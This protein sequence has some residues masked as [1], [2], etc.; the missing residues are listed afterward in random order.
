MAGLADEIAA[1]L[2]GLAGQSWIAVYDA[3]AESIL[4]KKGSG[5]EADPDLRDEENI[6]LLAGYLELDDRVQL[7]AVRE[8]LP[9]GVL[10]P[11][12]GERCRGC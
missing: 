2:A 4:A 9:V 11:G 8:V 7:N 3:D 5:Y 10:V 12:P 6:P 1:A